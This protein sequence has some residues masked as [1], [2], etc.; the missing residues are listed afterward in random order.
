M[1][2]VRR[3]LLASL[4]ATVPFAAACE[5]RTPSV[6]RHDAVVPS[7]SPRTAVSALESPSTSDAESTS[8]AQCLEPSL[9]TETYDEAA[10][11]F[12]NEYDCAEGGGI[13][14]VIT[15][16]S[17]DQLGNGEYTQTYVL[18]AGGEIVWTYTYTSGPTSTT[19]VGSSTEGESYEGTYTY[20]DENRTQV[21][22]TWTTAEGVYVTDGVMAND[23]S[24]FVGTT[25]FDDPDTA[26]SPDYSYEQQTNDDGSFSQRV[27][28][29]GDGWTSSYT[30]DFG[31]DGSVSYDF[32]TDLTDTDVEPDY[33]GT[34]TYAADGAGG[35]GYHQSY[36]DG[37]SLD[38]EDEIA[39]DGSYTESWSFDDAST[40][41][42]VDQEGSISYG[43]D[44]AGEGS[45]TTF[46][47]GGESE[48]CRVTI[49]AGGATTIDQCE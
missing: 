45:I 28:S 46:V 41:Q 35:G 33:E 10:G 49:D 16:G 30:A 4:A 3:A 9:V 37:S 15:E 29:A 5:G 26:A 22:E 17:G 44:G 24:S 18:E 8:E 25:T 48:T 13:D 32:A 19:Y 36:D 42:P 6:K 43:V 39:A 7:L 47:V 21:D 2:P 38:V 23:G 31:A 40:E 27:E 12:F 11:T 14:A 20:L 1:T 34:Y